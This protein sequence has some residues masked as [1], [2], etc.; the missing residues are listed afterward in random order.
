[1]SSRLR[2]ANHFIEPQRQLLAAGWTEAS[3]NP[4]AGGLLANNQG[5]QNGRLKVVVRAVKNF[6]LVTLK[7]ID[8]VFL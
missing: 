6:R 2:C 3:A 4:L 5:F 8:F 7:F 1:M